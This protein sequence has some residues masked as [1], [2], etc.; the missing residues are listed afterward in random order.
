M[1]G[2]SARFNRRRSSWQTR[3]R[4]ISSFAWR[5]SE[6]SAACSKVTFPSTKRPI[7]TARFG[8]LSSASPE[9]TRLT[10]ARPCFMRP[11]RVSTGSRRLLPLDRVA[12]ENLFFSQSIF[13]RVL[14]RRRWCSWRRQLRFRSAKLTQKLL[15]GFE[16]LPS[17][18]SLVAVIVFPLRSTMASVAIHETAVRMGGTG[19]QQEERKTH[20]ACYGDRRF[21]QRISENDDRNPILAKKR[22][23]QLPAGYLRLSIR[24][25]KN[26]SR[27]GR[28]V[29][30]VRRR[31]LYPYTYTRIPGRRPGARDIAENHPDPWRDDS[32]NRSFPSASSG[33]HSAFTHQR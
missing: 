5:N 16:G 31:S 24:N 9:A 17:K 23:Q 18:W 2:M 27:D 15:P 19:S 7:L 32:E 3:W 29:C 33:V 6:S 10:N 21:L 12:R 13:R 14:C 26:S 4:L 11:Q 8:T 22:G 1:T 25:S 30:I 20:P 28:T